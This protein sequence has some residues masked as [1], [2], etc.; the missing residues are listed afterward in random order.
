[1]ETRTPLIRK[2][3]ARGD[4]EKEMESRRHESLSLRREWTRAFTI[5]LVF[6]LLGGAAT[7][8]GVQ[9]I[10][11]QFSGASRQL[12][13]E[14]TLTDS[15][16]AQMLSDETNVVDL[17]AGLGANRAGSLKTQDGISATFATALV[18][19]PPSSRVLLR[20][21]RAE[22]QANDVGAGEWGSQV[23][24][25]HAT[26]SDTSPAAIAKFDG[27]VSAGARARA[28]VDALEAPSL[29]AMNAGLS[30]AGTLK[31]ILAGALSGLFA[32]ALAGMVYFR[33]RMATDLFRPVATM[34]TAVSKLEAGDLA[35][36]VEVV[37]HDE[38]GELAEAF[39]RMAAALHETQ[40]TL[41]QRATHDSL[42][43]L[44]NRAFLAER[45]AASFGPNRDRRARPESVLFIDV[46][47]FK[48][49]NDTLGHAAG[50]ELLVALAARLEAC[51]RPGDLVAR[52]GGDEFAMLVADDGDTTAVSVAERVLAAL[53]KPFDVSGVD[54]AVAVSIGVA[55]RR[56]DTVDAAELL[57]QADFAMYMAK[58]AGKGRF[59]IFDALMHDSMVGRVTLKADLAAAVANGQLRLD[60]QPVA[61]LGTG[62][63]V[64]VEA[65]VRWQ[66]PTL[67][68]LA[69]A[70]FIPLAEE[71][72]D[73]D[74]IGSWVLD[75]AARQVAQWR[76]TI[77]AHPDLWIS[78]N[79]SA[80]QLRLPRN[81]AAI[82]AILADPATEPLSVVLEITET[83]LAV[84]IDDAITSL[85]TLKDI[86]VR[87]AIDDFGT[88]YSSLSTL[89]NLPVD[90]LKIDRAFVSGPPSI[91]G[92]QPMLEGILGLA[93]RLNLTVIA[94]GIETPEQHQQ[95]RRL[96]C[97]LGQG[98]LL[99]R[100]APPETIQTLLATNQPITTPPA[101]PLQ[102]A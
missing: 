71:T 39:N 28:S 85:Q 51:V 2:I 95:L 18:V 52:L 9:A 48:D 36:R 26:L 83:A 40:Q 89:A 14:V 102:P 59:A 34:H 97:P 80:L 67:G 100:P 72:G 76:H 3:V 68:L 66:H 92:S 75:T 74:S 5:M 87:I 53:A 42:T 22:W 30:R 38:L 50:D 82:Q 86:G 23:L 93:N 33:R 101:T 61:D 91:A 29:A 79:L 25:S 16:R 90:I 54:M 60:Y 15:L 41:T 63:I 78:V 31:G 64:G 19:F 69:P 37:R 11:S 84:D 21:A 27:I 20:K 45:L 4:D 73:I 43:G 35:H 70:E 99:A 32:L 17:M 62:R 24:T 44:A 55:A 77:T 56:A 94:E 12:A 81:L 49:V 7:F 47:D 13:R 1:M 46:D 88:G 58:G 57:R 98:Y 10:V 65:L 6:I 96:G 8:V